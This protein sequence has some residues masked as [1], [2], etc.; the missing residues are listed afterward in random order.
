MDNQAKRQQL[1][2][3]IAN[4]KRVRRRLAMVVIALAITGLVV[5]H[6]AS[7][8]VGGV[9]LLLAAILTVTGFWITAAHLSDWRLAMAALPRQQ[10]N[11]DGNQ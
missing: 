6:T 8:A 1:E 4:S 9:L 11:H 10:N 5:R 3:W 7:H 2:A